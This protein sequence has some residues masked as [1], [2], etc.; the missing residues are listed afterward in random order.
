MYR[1]LNQNP[2]ARD[3]EDCTVR[4]ISLAQGKTWDKVY[5][6]LSVF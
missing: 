6:E 5:D 3:T 1:Y 2:K 4:A